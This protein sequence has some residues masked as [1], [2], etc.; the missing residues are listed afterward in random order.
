MPAQAALVPRAAKH[1]VPLLSMPPYK[2]RGYI[3]TIIYN[4]KKNV[5]FT[6]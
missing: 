5:M 3:P 6:G 2:C 1:V 4:K